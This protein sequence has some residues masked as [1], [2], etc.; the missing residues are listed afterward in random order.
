M[1]LKL[2]HDGKFI[3]VLFHHSNL[4][5]IELLKDKIIMPNYVAKIL[6]DKHPFVGRCTVSTI[7]ID[8]QLLVSGFSVCS[9]KDNFCRANGRKLSLARAIKDGDFDKTTSKKIW[10]EYRKNCK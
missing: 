4:S 9:L 8:G 5:D 1:S 7:K 2:E 3:E 6:P 10:E